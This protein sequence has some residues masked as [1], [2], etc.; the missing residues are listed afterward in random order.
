[1]NDPGVSSSA[2][3]G[4]DDLAL[5]PGFGAGLVVSE[6]VLIRAPTSRVWEVMAGFAAYPEWNPFNRSCDCA[7]GVGAPI[8]LGVAW[9]PYEGALGAATLTI[10]EVV[11]IWDPGRCLAYTDDRGRLHRAERI[12]LIRPTPEGA[13]YQT[14]QRWVGWMTPLI[15]ALYADR[16]REGFRAAS[17][18]VK[19][20][21]ESGRP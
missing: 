6:P 3:F 16:M 1:M 12:Q 17:L 9:G 10:R 18:A 7:G 19:A 21:A 4:P 5:P 15:Q 8:T 2:L 13:E 20:R 11:T 14:W